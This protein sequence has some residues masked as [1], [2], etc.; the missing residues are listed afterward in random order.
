MPIWR[1]GSGAWIFWVHSSARSS[2]LRSR[3]SGSRA[4]S[5]YRPTDRT[6]GT[7]ASP[8]AR[9]ACVGSGFRPVVVQV[10]EQHAARGPGLAQLDRGEVP[11]AEDEVLPRGALRH[12]PVP[13]QVLGD[14]ALAVVVQGVPGA[15]ALPPHA[16]VEDEVF[17]RQDVSEFR[18]DG[19]L[20]TDSGRAADG[21][22]LGV[23]HGVAPI[24]CR[25]P[26]PCCFAP[27]SRS[28]RA[29]VRARRRARTSTRDVSS[30]SP[31]S[32]PSRRPGAS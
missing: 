9:T 11:V 29:L 10:D 17:V 12:V 2:A 18:G 30:R 32:R 16:E 14:D 8:A 25:V 23:V 7:P 24:I 1:P 22:G 20:A 6:M 26:V 28:A 3:C 4:G 15:L 21:V 13:E 31:G 27:G 5:M 19:L